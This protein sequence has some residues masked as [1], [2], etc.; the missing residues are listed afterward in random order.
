MNK[1]EIFIGSLD[2]KNYFIDNKKF[3]VKKNT[4]PNTVSPTCR[5]NEK[6]FSHTFASS[7]K[8]AWLG[9]CSEC[10]LECRHCLY[11]SK[12]DLKNS[13]LPYETIRSS[14]IDL[15]LLL[16]VEKI[17]VSGGEPTLHPDFSEIIWSLSKAIPDTTVI[18][19]GVLLGDDKII[20]TFKETKAALQISL[21]GINIE[22]INSICEKNLPIILENAKS[23]D[24]VLPDTKKVIN[25]LLS[26]TTTSSIEDMVNFALFY[27]YEEVIFT[28]VK[29]IGRAK[30]NIYLRLPLK[31]RVALMKQIENLTKTSSI[32]I[33]LCGG[34]FDEL[35]V[36]PE[37]L[38]EK[39]SCD[40][41]LAA[42]EL[43]IR[44]DGRVMGCSSFFNLPTDSLPTIDMLL[45]SILKNEK[46][47]DIFNS[48]FSCNNFTKVM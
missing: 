41:S 37:H 35:D 7:Y 38:T 17:W 23:L 9:L 28:F 2:N 26:T 44:S 43:Q 32:P 20:N 5:E 33:I 3:L 27:G 39:Y 30:E 34:V 21:P 19:N 18:T 42:S 31:Q 1:N 12:K 45:E 10:N 16:Q 24:D 29:P 8:K 40:C 13:R 4:I 36:L 48:D 14:L 11:G 15:L 22:E 46:S 25:F 6:A 47:I